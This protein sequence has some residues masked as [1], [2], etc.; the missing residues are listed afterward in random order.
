M[1]NAYSDNTSGKVKNK[2]EDYS[3]S[4]RLFRKQL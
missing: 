4:K 1:C 2:L 3:S